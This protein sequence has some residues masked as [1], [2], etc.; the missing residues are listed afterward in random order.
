M[1]SLPSALGNG[2]VVKARVAISAPLSSLPGTE[3]VIRRPEH[4]LPPAPVVSAIASALAAEIA[5]GGPEE[6]TSF[7]SLL[8]GARR[9]A[10]EEG[11]QAGLAE[12]AASMEAQRTASVSAAAARLAEAAE[13]VVP[14]RAALLDEVG[15][16]VVD[17]AFELLEV[18]IGRELELGGTARD[19]VARALRLVPEGYDLIVRVHPDCGLDD[20]DIASLAATPAVEVVRDPAVDLRGCEVTVGACHVDAQI[21]SALARVRECLDAVAP[22]PRLAPVDAAASPEGPDDAAVVA[23]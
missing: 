9:Q 16:D 7:E 6:A 15:R 23:S 4:E 2:R 18:L 11:R 3:R 5:T 14:G 17:L 12:A 20:D 13:R 1:S 10:F 21:T 22:L 19:A 8:D